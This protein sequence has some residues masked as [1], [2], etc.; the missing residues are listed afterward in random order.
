[1]NE[2]VDRTATSF[3]GAGATNIDLFDAFLNPVAFNDHDNDPGTPPVDAS[4]AGGVIVQGM[5]RQ[6]GNE[7]DEFVTDAL[8]N[9]LVGLPL[10]LPAINMARG[11]SEGIPGLNSA[12]RQLFAASGEPLLTPYESWA[13][14]GLSIKHVESLA[15]FVAAYGT[16]PRIMSLDPDGSGPIT[17]GSLKARRIAAQQLVSTDTLPGPDGILGDDPLTSDEGA[18]DIP[19]V[20]ADPGP[21]GILGDNPLTTNADESADDTAAVPAGPGPDGVL[22]DNPLTT[23]ADESADD[24]PATP[25][26]PGPD[27]I[28]GDDPGTPNVNEG[29]DDILAP[30][31]S[32]QFIQGTGAWANVGGLPVTGLER[33]DFWLGGLAEKQ[34][35]FGGL[36]GSTFNFVFETQLENL[37]DGDRFYYLGRTAGLNMLTQLEG[38][39]FSELIMRNTSAEGLPAEVFARPDFTFDVPS[40]GMTGPILDD[41][42]TPEWDENLLLLRNNPTAGTVRFNGGEHVIWIGSDSV[43]DVDRIHSSEGDDTLR[44]NGGNDRAEGGA[45]NDQFI[46][47]EGNDL[48][49]DNFGD[50]VIKGG[51]GND[52]ISS[53][54]GFDLNQGGLGADFVW[55]GS[56]PTETFGGAGNDMIL[57]GQSSDTIFGDDGDDWIEGGNQADLLQGDNGA[58]FQ[59]DPNEPGN[60]V[61]IGD[62]GNDDYDSEGG[63]DIMVTGPGIERNEGMLGF[64][65]VTYRGDPQAA[66]ADMFFTGLLPPDLDNIADRFDNVEA[67]SGWKFNDILRGTDNDVTVLGVEHQLNAAGIARVSGLAAILPVGATT[68]NAGDIITGG[69]GNDLMEGRGG[70]DI[71]DGDRW[72][73]VQL[74]NGTTSGDAMSTFRAQVAAGTLDPGT[75]SIARTLVNPG[76]GTA[77]D[78]AVFSGARAE[79]VVTANGDGSTTVDH[80]GGID[81]VDTLWNIEQLQFADQTVPVSG[82]PAG[83]PAL[84]VSPTSS[85]VLPVQFGNVAVGAA[86]AVQSI[87]VSNTGGGSLDVTAATLTGPQAAQFS[88]LNNGCAGNPVG[89]GGSCAIQV[90]FSPTLLPLLV[91]ARTA[92]LNITTNATSSTTFLRGVRVIAAAL[93][94]ATIASPTDFGTRRVG[95]PRT[96]T[97]RVTND[98]AANNLTVTTVTTTGPFT[99]TNVDCTNVAP[100]GTCSLSVTFNPLAPLGAKSGTVRISGNITNAVAPGVLT[101]TSRA[102]AV[103]V[104]ALRIAQPPAPTSARPV[105]V[106]LRVSVAATVKVQVRRTNGKLVWSKVMKAKAGANSVRWNLRD[107][108]GRKVRKGSYRFTI[109]VT[110]ASGAKVVLKKTV[111]VR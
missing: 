15:N 39:S 75:I 45:G 56:D 107:A 49:S 1:L 33:V 54:Q 61:I 11:R 105:N 82:T 98:G 108:K 50:D 110:D 58:P 68:F 76:P 74:T 44:L 65:W 34:A 43:T 22:G 101:G 46:G 64:D 88:I 97:V 47:G 13:D 3:G 35:P 42:S 94:T 38:N 69:V 91:A 90:G 62:G 10:D 53:G 29:V 16:H 60:D 25:A 40:L 92:Q 111:R 30:G 5:S 89:A 99:A 18:D 26:L 24:T 63:D 8:R 37:Q 93:T 79:Y 4:V 84:S 86:P 52:Y 85:A 19:A 66:N 102:A 27:G 106:S 7:L 31:D 41:P 9:R 104:A 87:T 96:R 100:G 59:N 83:T 14:F 70:D 48:L 51:H 109:T 78:T 95:E 57:A 81:G 2:T 71:I 23:N 73:N 55:G 77:T 32:Q 21:D 28:L 103:V 17:A 12:R 6:V 36:L 80:Q 20:P 72:L 67:L